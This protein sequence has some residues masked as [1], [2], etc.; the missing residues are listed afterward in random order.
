MMDNSRYQAEIRVLQSKL[1]SN[2]YKFMDMGTST[3]YVIMAARTNRGNIYTLRIELRDFPTSIPK[4]FV[5]KMLYTKAGEPMNNC[6]ASMHTL[7]SENGWTRICHYGNNA[8]TPGVS[9]YKVYVKC[10]LWLE[11]YEQHLKTGK[12][13]DYYL[14]HQA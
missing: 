2:L 11:V 12:P 1:P 9:I 10:R 8:W 6:S 5:Q 13:L 4:V 14:A 3:P 7:T